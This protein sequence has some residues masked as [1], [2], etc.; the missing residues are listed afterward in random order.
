MYQRQHRDRHS[1]Q[2]GQPLELNKAIAEGR[3]VSV[4]STLAELIRLAQNL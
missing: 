4:D 1:W 2:R 3:P